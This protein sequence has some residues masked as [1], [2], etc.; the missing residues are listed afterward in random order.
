MLKK[1]L[2]RFNKP[3]PVQLS[4][5]FGSD[6]KFKDCIRKNFIET[7]FAWLG[8]SISFNISCK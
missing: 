8:A 3:R 2:E 4:L 1:L 7:R 5:N 6:I